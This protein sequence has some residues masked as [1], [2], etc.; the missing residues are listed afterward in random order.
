MAGL[1]DE[2][3][4]HE[5]RY[6]GVT[7]TR[8]AEAL[9]L[10]GL[11]LGGMVTSLC[12]ADGGTHSVGD[13]RDKQIVEAIEPFKIAE[14]HQLTA[15]MER[16]MVDI[17]FSSQPARTIRVPD[18]EADLLEHFQ[19]SLRMPSVSLPTPNGSG[20]RTCP[21]AMLPDYGKRK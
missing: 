3:G 9:V 4:E 14:L 16:A 7:A 12:H 1:L 13:D 11:H 10:V 19:R 2:T 15:L 18:S 5:H 6:N 21:S 20:E 8:L 17:L